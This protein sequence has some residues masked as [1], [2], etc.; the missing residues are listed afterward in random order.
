VE[1]L[2]NFSKGAVL[3]AIE[4][5]KSRKGNITRGK[6]SRKAPTFGTFKFLI[7]I[8]IIIPAIFMFTDPSA[9]ASFFDFQLGKGFEKIRNY[10]QAKQYYG[11]AWNNSNKT[12]LQARL[13]YAEMCNQE[14]QYEEALN[15]T[16]SMIDFGI[17][18]ELLLSE[19]QRQ[20][21]DAN[22]G[23]DNLDDAIVSYTMATKLNA[24]NYNAM[25]GLGRAYRLK[26]DNEKARSYLE[27]AIEMK[28]LR[29]PE[30][31]YELGLALIAQGN[32]AEAL[33]QFDLVLRQMASRDLREKAREQKINIIANRQ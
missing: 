1:G 7:A 33:D 14:K 23:L 18:D 12:N 10:P 24:N 6:A 20:N 8:L 30:A 32:G 4:S 25:V 26:G 17:S 31:H 5:S 15:V 21:G 28:N 2:N 11:A 16:Q 9:R 27:D 3:M 29:A 19:V 22:V 13:K